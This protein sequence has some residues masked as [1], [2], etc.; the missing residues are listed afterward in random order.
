[1]KALG[2]YILNF[3]VMSWGESGRVRVLSTVSV[4]KI[5]LYFRFGWW[6]IIFELLLVGNIVRDIE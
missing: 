5:K 1:M 3:Y 4:G 6:E 2:L